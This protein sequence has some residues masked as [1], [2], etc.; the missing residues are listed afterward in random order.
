[1]GARH[2]VFGAEKRTEEYSPEFADDPS[3]RSP[4]GHL[5]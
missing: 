4:C 5:G 3:R 2:L 1:M